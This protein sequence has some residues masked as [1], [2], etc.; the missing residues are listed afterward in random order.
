MKIIKNILS[1]ILSFA[2]IFAV[3]LLIGI[4]ILNTKFLNKNYILFKI[5][6]LAFYEQISRETESGFEEYI[7]Q[8]GLP[9]DVIKDLYSDELLRKD[10]NNLID[11]LYE[12]RGISLSDETVRNTLDTKIREYLDSQNKK[13]NSDGEKNIKKFEDLIVKEYK[14]NVNASTTFYTKGYT[15]IDSVNQIVNKFGNWPQIILG[16][17]VLLLVLVNIKDL[18]LAINYLAISS[19]SIGILIKLGINLLFSNIDFDNLLIFAKS[20]SN[21]IVEIVKENLYIISENGNLFIVCGIT[22]ILITAILREPKII[23]KTMKR[24]TNRD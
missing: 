24:A 17:L 13:L 8:S 4:D 11:C 23:K 2:I 9:K 21:L 19:L 5:D 6:E 18:L 12:G 10:V 3:F 1:L 14:E 15:I 16:I 22:G 20:L 7:Y